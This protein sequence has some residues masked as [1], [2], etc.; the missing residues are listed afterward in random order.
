M[1]Q[2]VGFDDREIR[3]LVLEFVE[4]VEP[5][6]VCAGERLTQFAFCNSVGIAAPRSSWTSAIIFMLS[7]WWLSKLAFDRRRLER[8]GRLLSA[9]TCRR[10][11]L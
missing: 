3:V 9:D 5:K 8:E 1:T 4:L 11:R 10:K 2:A 7:G 6:N